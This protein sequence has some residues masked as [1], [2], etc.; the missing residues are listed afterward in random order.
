MR[1]RRKGTR[2]GNEKEGAREGAREK[3]RERGGRNRTERAQRANDGRQR[4]PS[5]PAPR[6]CL[7]LLAPPSRSLSRPP[8]PPPPP[9]PRSALSLPHRWC[10]TARRRGC[11]RRARLGAPGRS[12]WL[13]RRPDLR[14]SGRS[15]IGA[16]IAR[17]DSS[18]PAAPL[19]RPRREGARRGAQP[20]PHA[21]SERRCAGSRRDGAI[22]RH[23]GEP[24]LPSIAKDAAQP[25]RVAT[26]EQRQATRRQT[27][28]RRASQTWTPRA[29]R[30]GGAE[31]GKGGPARAPPA[32]A[33]TPRP[34]PPL[35]PSRHSATP[36]APPP[37]APSPPPLGPR[38]PPRA[39]ACRDAHPAPPFKR[40]SS[41]RAA[42]QSSSARIEG[43]FELARRRSV[44]HRAEAMALNGI[45]YRC[46]PL[47]TSCRLRPPGSP[48][49]DG[50][51]GGLDPR[52]CEPIRGLRRGLVFW[53]R[54]VPRAGP[55][56]AAR[57]SAGSPLRPSAR[58][59]CARPAARAAIRTR[60]ADRGARKAGEGP[61]ARAIGE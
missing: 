46:A 37:L 8:P 52:R 11:R 33:G 29:R 35:P 25:P 17:D 40:R 32:E 4:T 41:R 60:G 49:T 23:A 34:P 47:A 39:G 59:A 10:P 19:R 5:R 48:R 14:E 42:R 54:A 12:A 51:A 22:R 61:K 20:R 50:R 26:H 38:L 28:E 44:A 30:A 3:E 2:R 57:C 9:P 21:R 43:R 1:V 31:P 56:G 58:P 27:P 24:H 36:T 18:R 45:Q 13:A 55:S 53:L 15:V 7:S 16:P 6:S